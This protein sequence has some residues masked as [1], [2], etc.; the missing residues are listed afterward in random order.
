MTEP[1]S[2]AAWLAT[3]VVL[4][5]VSSNINWGGEQWRH[6][7]QAD[8][9]GYHAYL[10]A[11]LLYGD[12]NLGFFTEIEQGKYYNENFFY[13]YRSAH[14]GHTVN[15]YFAGTA[16]AQLPFFLLAHV[17]ALIGPADADGF[18]KPYSI[19]V[20]LAAIA[21]TLLGLWCTM[22]LLASFGVEDRWRAFTILAF[23]LGT[24][25]FY[26]AVVAPGMSH[27]YSFGACT[28]FLLSMRQWS[29]QGR[30]QDLIVAGLLLGLIVLIRPVNALVVFALP[31][32]WERPLDVLAQLVK[33]P[34]PTLS[35]G[36][37]ALLIAGVQPLYY[38]VATGSWFVYSYGEEGF[39]WHDPHFLDILFSYR[40]GL[41]VY[42]P[43]LLLACGG[44]W[45][46]WERSR[47]QVISWLL[48]IVALTYVL[49]SWWNWWY[50][51]SFGSRVYV[52]YLFLFALPFALALQWLGGRMRKAYIAL[53]VILVL[54]CQ[55]QIYQM[56]YSRIHWDGMDRE[57]YWDVFLRIDRL[58]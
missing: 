15:K 53:S 22:R 37:V 14:D 48:F 32:V 8:A 10:P 7:V 24:N 45:F 4:V 3:A 42:A 26:Y 17:A 44:L 34:I 49:G 13:D 1:W 58:F 12:P 30:T 19:G 56:R 2:R 31:V 43:L 18:S 20:N 51:G 35:A 11:I 9:K 54:V 25:L 52:E 6:I 23:V 36:I 29:L 55:I 28:A 47:T 57:Q 5:W 40:K 33:R 50:G 16:V 27:A 41:F 39:R 21:W 46:M 38:K